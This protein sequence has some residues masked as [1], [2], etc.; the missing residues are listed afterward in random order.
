MTQGR[1]GYHHG[2]LREA[3][4]EAAL[5]LIAER[6]PIGV[7]FAEAARRA[8]VSSA[9]PY[10]HFRDREDL[11]V[12]TAR[13]GFDKFAAALEAAWDGGKPTPLSAFDALGRAYLR[14]A[15]E[16]SAFFAAMFD[17]GLRATHGADLAAAGARAF[18][19]LHG[20]C[21]ALVAHLPPGRRPPV[22]M[23][24]YHVWALSHGIATLFGEAD[25][26]HA[27]IAPEEML[28][29]GTTIYLRGLGLVPAD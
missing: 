27:P 18:E 14:F 15:R 9:A 19:A 12:E 29:A 4:I 24:A 5:D 21:A 28:E 17:P 6:G 3:L 1:K 26:G 11:L 16:E 8:G 20:A 23:M 22:H 2:N 25:T 7:S 10:R 13:I